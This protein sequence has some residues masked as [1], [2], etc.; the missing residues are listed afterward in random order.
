MVYD[1]FQAYGPGI[2]IIIFSACEFYTDAWRI[3]NAI[4]SIMIV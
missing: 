4:I 3:I 2:I 1:Y